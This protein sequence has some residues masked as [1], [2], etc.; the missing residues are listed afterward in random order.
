M[1]S[2]N[3]SEWL[4]QQPNYVIN[5]STISISRNSSLSE[6]TKVWNK[7]NII[8]PPN[9]NDTNSISS[10][11]SVEAILYT[12]HN[13]QLRKGARIRDSLPGIKNKFG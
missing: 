9:K 1:S 7:N 13:H 6:P 5:I 12:K 11:T 4:V 2:Q 8:Y 3:C 10:D